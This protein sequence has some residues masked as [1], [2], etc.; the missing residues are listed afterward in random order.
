MKRIKLHEMEERTGFG[1]VWYAVM[2][3]CSYWLYE[4]RY[5][6]MNTD[7]AGA[8]Y[9]QMQFEKLSPTSPCGTHPPFALPR[10][11]WSSALAL[12]IV[13]IVQNWSWSSW[14]SSCGADLL[15]RVLHML[16]SYDLTKRKLSSDMSEDGERSAAVQKEFQSHNATHE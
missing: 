3:P 16:L 2:C 6:N 8:M 9:I 15:P 11:S 1:R 14:R 5:R 13:C 7:S 10:S 12:Q 4:I